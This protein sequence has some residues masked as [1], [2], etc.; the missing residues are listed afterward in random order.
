MSEPKPTTAPKIFYLQWARNEAMARELSA[1]GWVYAQ[2][3]LSH[4]N[5][6]SVLYRSPPGWV[7]ED[8]TFPENP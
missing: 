5:E 4:H 2:E 3:I 8:L 1:A 6:Y 7:P